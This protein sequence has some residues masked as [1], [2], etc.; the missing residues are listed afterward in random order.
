MAAPGAR[1]RVVTYNLHG[2]RDDRNAMVSLLRG[3]APDVL[4]LQEAPRRFRWR[5]GCAALAHALGMVVATGGQP[6]LGNLILTD[7]RVAVKQ[8]W[9]V[10][11]PLTPGRHLR[12]VALADCLVAGVSLLVAGSHLSTDPTERPGQAERLVEVLAEHA[13]TDGPLVLGVDVNDV[14]GS[15]AW[16]ALAD[17]L[18]DTT[19][20][21]G[22]GGAAPTFPAVSPARRLDA[23]FTRGPVSVLATEVVDAPLARRASDHLP[24]LV[25]LQLPV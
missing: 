2:L 14:P 13:G 1:L 8:A 24:V 11:F 17:T 23:V 9:P 15:P 19:A 6:A 3:L 4:I 22:V 21:A 10:R 5:H 7:L 18:T 25:D 12:G 20:A 16:Q